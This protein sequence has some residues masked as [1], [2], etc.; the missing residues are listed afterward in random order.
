MLEYEELLGYV[1]KYQLRGR[2]DVVSFCMGY[3]GKLD[4]SHYKMIEEMYL[5]GIVKD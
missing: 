1:K 4:E 2:F 5:D 3:C